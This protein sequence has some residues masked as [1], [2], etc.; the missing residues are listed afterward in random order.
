MRGFVRLHRRNKLIFLHEVHCS[1]MMCFVSS[2]ESLTQRHS[3]CGGVGE[4]LGTWG[5]NSE[6]GGEIQK[7]GRNFLHG[8]EIPLCL[9]FQDKSN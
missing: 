9:G 7:W 8:A 4:R 1:V 2:S 5:R 6:R 3:E